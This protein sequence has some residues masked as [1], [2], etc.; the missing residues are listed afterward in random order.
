VQTTCF[1]GHHAAFAWLR[2]HFPDYEVALIA[3]RTATELIRGAR[4][5][6]VAI[7]ANARRTTVHHGS[8]QR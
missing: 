4:K 6:M 3:G 5:D 7:I 8:G 2:E 1:I